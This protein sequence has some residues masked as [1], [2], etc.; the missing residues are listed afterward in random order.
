MKIT[1]TTKQP[2]TEGYYLIHRKAYNNL[3]LVNVRHE[4][5]S[6]GTRGELWYLDGISHFP[7]KALKK[8]SKVFYSQRLNLGKLK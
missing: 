2:K 1:W 8:E 3:N 7:M 4:S 5:H 6:D